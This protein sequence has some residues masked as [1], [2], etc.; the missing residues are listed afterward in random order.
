VGSFSVEGQWA[1][2]A[3][4]GGA[5]RFGANSFCQVWIR[6]KFEFGRGKRYYGHMEY[7]RM[8]FLFRDGKWER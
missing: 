2:V 3:V 5:G 8:V 7:K 6:W 1:Q 4:G